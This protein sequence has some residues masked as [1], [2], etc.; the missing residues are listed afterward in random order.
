MCGGWVEVLKEE[1]YNKEGNTISY[2]DKTIEFPWEIQQ[3]VQAW[4]YCFIFQDIKNLIWPHTIT[5]IKWGQIDT[6]EQDILNGISDVQSL[7]IDEKWNWAVLWMGESGDYF[8][9]TKSFSNHKLE[10]DISHILISGN[11]VT[12]ISEDRENTVIDIQDIINEEQEKVKKRVQEAY[13]ARDRLSSSLWKTKEQ[14]KEEQENLKTRIK[15]LKKEK[16]KKEEELTHLEE[17]FQK[18]KKEV[19]EIL[20]L[21][22][23]GKSNWKEQEE[24][25]VHEN[26]EE[27]DKGLLEEKLSL[28]KKIKEV[29]QEIEKI[30]KEIK[31]F[32]NNLR[33]ILSRLSSTLFSWKKN[34]SRDQSNDIKKLLWINSNKK[35][36]PILPNKI[37]KLYDL[38]KIDE[39]TKLKSNTPKK[40]ETPEWLVPRERRRTNSK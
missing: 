32:K 40:V 9:H 24:S 12:L 26:Q 35:M 10:G 33:F 38:L 3:V 27:K 36:K 39:L 4:E 30:K 11:S 34:F 15:E 29:N 20:S 5:I 25:S 14:I 6:T 19:A 18:L 37:Q 28:E 23:T 7:A 31:T 13:K 22:Y 16:Q 1:K 17:G 8:L 21:F 2:W